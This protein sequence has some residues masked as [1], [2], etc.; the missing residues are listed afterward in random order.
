MLPRDL[1]LLLA[2]S[3]VA[4]A[5]VC[6]PCWADAQVR[7]P[8]ATIEATTVGSPTYDR[9]GRVVRMD[10]KRFD[11]SGRLLGVT[12]H[13]YTR[14]ADGKLKTSETA[15]YD[16]E[17]LQTSRVFTRWEHQVQGV[18]RIGQRQF[19][20]RFDALTRTETETWTIDAP[21]R[22]TTVEVLRFDPE[23]LL[24]Q[25]RYE[26]IERD[27][28]G[29]IAGWDRAV[30]DAIGAQL[31]RSLSEWS[32]DANKL[33]DVERYYFDEADDLVR[34]ETEV[35]IYIGDSS[36]VSRIET[37][38]KGGLENVTG[39]RYEA[40]K[41]DDKYLSERITTHTDA[42]DLLLQRRTESITRDAQGRLKARR[43]KWETY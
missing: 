26:V 4:T 2:G 10:N 30:Y 1:R 36:R 28:R 17:D 20:D 11:E 43:V 14:Y 6:A 7:L 29:R 8:Q 37:T 33:A 16:A 3:L 12:V 25:T 35:R 31:S 24:Q 5:L 13:K 19:Y 18:D 21:L 23:G 22:M 9:A 42:Q 41:Y 27:Y 38:I 39:Y 40:R 34:R 15:C 32:Y